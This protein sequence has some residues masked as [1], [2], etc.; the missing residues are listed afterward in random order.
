M[1]EGRRA[2]ALQIFRIFA[3]KLTRDPEIVVFSPGRVIF[4]DVNCRHPFVVHASQVP[5]P[6]TLRGF[7]RR[8]ARSLACGLAWLSCLVA[9]VA[10]ALVL[11]PAQGELWLGHRLE[12]RIPVRMDPGL[13]LVA[14]CVDVRVLDGDTALPA[15][16]LQLSVH[17]RGADSFIEL[18]STHPLRAAFVQLTLRMACQFRMQRHYTLLVDPAPLPA[19]GAAVAPAADAAPARQPGKHREPPAGARDGAR[20]AH[21]SPH[22]RQ[23]VHPK[24]PRHAATPR[25]P[26]AEAAA[27]TS[28]LR[29]DWLARSIAPPQA[30]AFG[31]VGTAAPVAAASSSP[32]G[33][34]GTLEAPPQSQQLHQLELRL[35]ALHAQL[36]ALQSRDAALQARLQA[37]H[38]RDRARQHEAVE[39]RDRPAHARG[40]PAL[41]WGG[42][43]LLLAAVCGWLAAVLWR[44]RRRTAETP[45][46]RDMPAPL[47]LPGAAEAPAPTAAEA[48]ALGAATTELVAVERELFQRPL[49]PPEQLQIDEM[50]DH[51]H[52]AD[53]FVGIGEPD[54][55]IDV[56]RRALDEAAGG[57]SAMPYLA[58][59][60]L[61][62]STGRRADYE[63]LERECG[64]RLNL[65]VPHWD[66][67]GPRASRDLLD[68]P[69]ALRLL[70]EAWGTPACLTV[71]ERMIA[72]DPRRPRAGFELAAYRDLLDLYAL[73][74]EMQ[75]PESEAAAAP[76]RGAPDAAVEPGLDLQLNLQPT[77][78]P[79]P[80]AA[81]VPL[82]PRAGI[83]PLRSAWS[84]SLPQVPDDEASTLQPLDFTWSTLPAPPPPAPAGR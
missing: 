27:P 12:L 77:T 47:A 4:R 48:P 17:G 57:F 41:W 14:Q 63:Q 69:R 70:G 24:P 84:G 36:R 65:R 53:F 16:E 59:F 21:A 62:R 32:A 28:R 1:E 71:I 39:L 73:V 22:R 42:A 75:R 26:P 7:A 19:A 74:R 35:D 76:G 81:S 23:A 3:N 13:P 6:F 44:G 83:P 38:G 79:K 51:G 49:S 31:A 33:L 18:R 9:P 34:P 11:G 68:Y 66:E 64:S 67:A 40:A 29:L 50:V 20:R 10:H 45:W 30:A 54:K 60:E 55:A 5:P 8:H 43:W 2:G 56:M 37:L 46:K 78:H 52:L 25:T 15:H 80:R 58:L 82:S 72:D 61:Y